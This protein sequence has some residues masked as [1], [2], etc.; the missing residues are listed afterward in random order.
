MF[1]RQWKC[2]WDSLILQHI[3][4]VSKESWVSRLSGGL[5]TSKGCRML[6]ASSVADYRHTEIDLPFIMHFLLL[7]SQHLQNTGAKYR[8]G[9]S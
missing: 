8:C 9:F 2:S 3:L 1:G 7:A 5:P 4:D 6:D